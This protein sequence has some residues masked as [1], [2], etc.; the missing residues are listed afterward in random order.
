MVKSPSAFVTVSS[1]TFVNSLTTF[2]VAPGTTA[3]ELSWTTP[4]MVPRSDWAKHAPQNKSPN[5]NTHEARFKHRR[6]I[7]CSPLEAH[8]D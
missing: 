3:P 8:R 4:L 5:I 1:A 6:I 2:T 7:R